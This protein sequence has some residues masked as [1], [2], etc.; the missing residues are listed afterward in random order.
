[1]I[2]AMYRLEIDLGGTTIEI[3]ALAEQGIVRIRHAAAG[4]VCGATRLWP[5]PDQAGQ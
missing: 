2:I 1:M 4:G 5:L 3:A